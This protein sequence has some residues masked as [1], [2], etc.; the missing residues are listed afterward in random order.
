MPCTAPNAASST[1]PATLA[2]PKIPF[3]SGIQLAA[4]S[5]VNALSCRA[6]MVQSTVAPTQTALRMC[7]G[8]ITWKC[9]E[10]CGATSTVPTA[11]IR[12]RPPAAAYPATIVRAGR[13]DSGRN[14]GKILPRLSWQIADTAAI[15]EISAPST[16]TCDG[17]Y[18]CAA[19]SQKRKPL[20]PV[21]TV[22]SIS[23]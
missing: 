13:D 21:S 6:K 19:I 2:I 18:R 22:L 7:V 11:A 17:S 23:A 20:P 9:G 8:P 14:R 12:E 10:M 3:S 16:P 15:R 5:P 4:R 1:K